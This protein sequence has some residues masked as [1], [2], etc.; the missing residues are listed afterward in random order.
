MDYLRDDGVFVLRVVGCNSTEMV[1][2]DLVVELWRSFKRKHAHEGALD[3]RPTVGVN[4][5]VELDRTDLDLDI[6]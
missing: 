1:L 2:K 5:D 4:G 6:A 3:R